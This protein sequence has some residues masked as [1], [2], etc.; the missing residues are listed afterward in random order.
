MNPILI[1]LTMASASATAAEAQPPLRLPDGE[2]L[3][4]VYFFGHWWEPWKS[5]DEAIRRDLKRLREMG[6]NTLLVDHEFSQMLDGNWKW[7]DREHR[8]AKECGFTLVPWLEAHCGRDIAV[9]DRR[10]VASKRFGVPEVPLTVTQDGQP[11][12]ALITAEAFKQY[13]SAYAA[14]YLERYRDDGALLR[15]MKD[16]KPRPV[17][18]LSVEMDFTAFDPE[19]NEGFRKWLREKYGADVSAL[20][21]AWGT[22]FESF[23]QVDPQD[24]SIF[25]YS[26]LEQNVPPAVQDH[27]AFRAQVCNDVFADVKARV[28]EK[29]PD[30]LFLAEVPY[31]FEGSHPHAIGYQWSCAM[32]PEA[33]RFADILLLRWTQGQPTSTEGRAVRDYARDSGADTVICYRVSTL[34]NAD[35]GPATAEIANGLGYYSWNEMV[36]CHAAENPPGVG[37]DAFRIDAAMSRDLVARMEAANRAYLEAVS[38]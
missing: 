28:A 19:T 30:T 4:A 32:L 27:A 25:D 7:L 10:Q 12:A 15:V 8:L 36:D 20:N 14:A 13:L 23:E 3:M 35:F 34:L 29:Y 17:I 26:N 37:I 11:G 6:F 16:G 5:D 31:Q 1:T 9:G 33:V 24:K 18:S 21:A 22:K 38:R 2:P